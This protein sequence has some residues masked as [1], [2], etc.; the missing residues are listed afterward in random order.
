[1][2]QQTTL[3][4]SEHPAQDLKEHV[5][6]MTRDVGHIAELQSKLLLAEWREA[7]GRLYCAMGCWLTATAFVGAALPVA[8]GGC[9]L[10]IADST[11]LGIAAGLLC[12]AAGAV[13]LASVLALVGWLQFRRQSAVW[14][15]A[16]QEII[17]SA[18][19]VRAAFSN[20]VATPNADR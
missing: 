5:A 15:Q 13:A 18:R 20:A 14:E 10:W 2:D 9:G 19:A 8:V 11:E 6:G 7:R 1:M 12:A 16:R 17:E 3:N 4:G